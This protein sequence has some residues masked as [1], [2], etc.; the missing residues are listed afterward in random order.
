MSFV[1]F[2]RSGAGR[3]LRIV[4]GAALIVGGIAIGGTGG[5]IFAIV[6]LRPWRQGRLTSA[7]SRRCSAW[8]SWAASAR[9]AEPEP[10][11]TG[12]SWLRSRSS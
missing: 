5:T 8:T 2:M 3:G 6:G 12:A 9:R 11:A 1:S 7:R 4:A 10:C